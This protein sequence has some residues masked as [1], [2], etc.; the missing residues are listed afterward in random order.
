MKA[1]PNEHYEFD[2]WSGDVSSNQIE[3]NFK[4]NR[5]VRITANFKMIDSDNDGVPDKDD[6][7]PHTDIGIEVNES[8]MFTR[9]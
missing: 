4:I 9:K 6:L 8:G 7:C 5:N 1:F 2:F 3:I